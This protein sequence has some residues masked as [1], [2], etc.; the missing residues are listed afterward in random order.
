MHG[1]EEESALPI[2]EKLIMG[3]IDYY[4]VLIFVGLL[5][6]I[7]P[8][9]FLYNYKKQHLIIFTILLLAFTLESYGAYTISRKINNIVAYN[10]FFFYLETL[11]ILWFFESFF[12]TR[13][14][15]ITIRVTMFTFFLWAIG[16]NLYLGDLMT[17]QTFSFTL[18]STL[19]IFCCI[20]FFIAIFNK[21]WFID[22]SLTQ[23]PLFWIT[24]LIFL[25]YSSTFIYFTSV[26][27]ITDLDRD[28]ILT[29]GNIKRI[30]AILMYLGMGL[31]FYLPYLNKNAQ[32][33]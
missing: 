8:F 15:K 16:Y 30:I 28:L 9:F 31:A 22:E 7:P 4:V 21:D 2:V 23:N 25:F 10:I 3:L 26:T 24:N 27:L 18:G 13:K 29:L 11:L 14:S 20:Y 1:M 33:A 32:K 19:I 17:F 6:S 12:K 5:L